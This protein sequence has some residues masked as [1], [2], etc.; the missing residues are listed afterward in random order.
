MITW[1]QV[2]TELDVSSKLRFHLPASRL[3]VLLQ[4]RWRDKLPPRKSQIQSTK[5]V[6]YGHH[7]I[8]ENS[9]KWHLQQPNEFSYTYS[10]L[11]NFFSKDEVF[12]N[13]MW[14]Q[15]TAALRI[16]TKILNMAFTVL[17]GM[18]LWPTSPTS[19][20]FR[21]LCLHTPDTLTFPESCKPTMLPLSMGLS[22]NA[23]LCL[24]W[25]AFPSLP[26]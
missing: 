9:L 22:H 10:G 14:S 11:S 2:A 24:Q 1:D 17:L 23:S 5:M 19:L 16:K 13:E 21:L 3:W 4:G 7:C 12:E 25:P 20:C 18:N 8:T 26:R 15:N 6:K